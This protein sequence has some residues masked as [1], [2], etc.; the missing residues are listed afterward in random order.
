[1]VVIMANISNFSS[2]N[3]TA[4]SIQLQQLQPQFKISIWCGRSGSVYYLMVFKPV[5]NLFEV[6]EKSNVG[7]SLT[8][9]TVP[10][11]IRT[12]GVSEIGYEDCNETHFDGEYVKD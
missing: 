12:S 10:S 4:G 3:A 9:G 6:T 8:Y 1:M 7:H 11:N 5:I 2:Q